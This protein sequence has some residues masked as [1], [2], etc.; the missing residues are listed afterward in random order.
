MFLLMFFFLDFFFFLGQNGIIYKKKKVHGYNKNNKDEDEGV[1]IRTDI[2]AIM[3]KRCDE[4]GK[5]IV[6]HIK[7]IKPCQLSVR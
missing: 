1:S 5:G 3:I 6:K 2:T 7:S 4:V